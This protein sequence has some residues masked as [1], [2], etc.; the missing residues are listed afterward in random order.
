M[1]T[2]W[3]ERDAPNRDARVSQEGTGAG[4]LMAEIVREIR[5]PLWLWDKD[6]KRWVPVAVLNGTVADNAAWWRQ[7]GNT[8]AIVGADGKPPDAPPA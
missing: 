2:V 8:V 6:S 5:S 7:R 4:K 3:R 1:T